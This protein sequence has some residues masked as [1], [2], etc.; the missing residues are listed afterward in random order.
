MSPGR[1]SEVFGTLFAE[2]QEGG[3]FSDSKTFADA[4]ALRAPEAILDA[5]K[6]A[7]PLGDD[8]LLAFVR[9]HFELPHTE[10]SAAPEMLPLADFITMLWPTLTRAPV[11]SQ[12]GSSLLDLPRR[13]VVPG[14]RFRELYYWDSYFTM[15]GLVRS[16][17]QDLVEDMIANFG[18]LI[19][20][21][22]YIP[23]GTRSYYLSRSHPPVFYLMAALCRDRSDGARHERLRW[24]R[25]EHAFWM[26][27]ADTLRAG[28]E[29][30]RVVRLADGALL[31]RYWDDCAAPRDESW[32]EDVELSRCVP[33]RDSGALWR[34]I[35]AAAES[36][37]DFSSRWLGDAHSLETIRTTRL[38]PIDLNALL[39][40]L[41]EA[42]TREA[43]AL[44]D[45]TVAR[46]FAGR[47][48]ARRDAIDRHL[49]NEQRQFF[50]D[51][52]LDAGAPRDQLTAAQG[53]ALFT[54]AAREERGPPVARALGKLL[55]AGGLLA[56][57]TVTGQQWD[58]PNGWAP[59]QWV[60]IEGLRAYG[61]PALADRI[62]RHWLAMVEVHYAATG[63]LL[64]KYDVERCGAGGGGE[65]GTEVGFGWTNGVTLELLCRRAGAD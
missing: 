60:A 6:A 65:Y 32:R 25:A 51:F 48:V 2:V 22:G 20:R 31:N 43:A 24:I 27:G 44:G 23:N 17:R 61:E 7:G 9:A 36:G 5:R 8:G 40:G 1:P 12:P 19:D 21:F 39:F 63:Q 30:R 26:A 13:H 54:G 49:W 11:Q 29:H 59:L 4:V 18:S 16:G 47:A 55:R 33:K 34:D 64:E 53:F 35:R 62:A 15:L 58:A 14:G 3:I 37:W 56:T 57:D 41:E 46:D 45:D 38:L 10:D 28:G 42:I 50:A 52:D